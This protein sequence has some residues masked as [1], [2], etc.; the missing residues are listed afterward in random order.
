[1]DCEQRVVSRRVL[2]PPLKRRGSRDARAFSAWLLWSAIP[3]L[4][5][6][7]PSTHHTTVTCDT[8]KHNSVHPSKFVEQK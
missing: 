4:Y 2:N 7:L 3:G 8:N 5:V 6:G 1:M